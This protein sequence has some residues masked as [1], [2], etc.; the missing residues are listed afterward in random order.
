MPYN[1]PLNPPGV[2]SDQKVSSEP[3]LE[4]KRKK[5]AKRLDNLKLQTLRMRRGKKD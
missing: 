1:N 3:Q 2:D 4:S 5:M